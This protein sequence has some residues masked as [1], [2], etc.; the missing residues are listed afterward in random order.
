MQQQS[1]EKST[2]ARPHDD[3]FDFVFH[4]TCCRCLLFIMIYDTV[5]LIAREFKFVERWRIVPKAMQ[6]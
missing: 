5:I 6:T 1:T 4:R 3:T 2:T